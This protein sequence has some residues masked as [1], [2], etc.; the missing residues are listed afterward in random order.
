MI[1]LIDTR[2]VKKSL[3]LL[4][5]K[6]PIY[7]FLLNHNLS[8]EIS[9]IFN[10]P[11]EGDSQV[12][13]DIL[14]GY[15]SFF[16]ETINYKNSI[17][18]KNTSTDLWKEE[19]H[20][21]SWVRDLRAV[22]TNKAR[23]FLRKSI[24]DWILKYNKW[25]LT[26]W[27]SDIIGKRVYSLLGNFNFF[28]S[29]AENDFQKLMLESLF[30]QGNHL[31]KNKLQDIHGY[32]RIFAIKGLIAVSITYTKFNEH[33]DFAIK[34]LITEISNQ[35]LNDGSHYLKSPSKHSEFLQN[36]IDIRSYL[37]EAKYK[38]P[39]KINE[40]ILIMASVLKFY[41]I[42]GETLATFNNSKSINK[43][44]LNQIILR[45]NSKLKI[46]SSLSCSGFQKISQN[47]INFFMDCGPPVKEDTYAGSLSFELSIGKNPI[48]VNCGSPY[49]NNKI[50]T[51]A[52][53][54]TAAHS[55]LSVDNINSSDIFFNKRQ[56][57]SRIANVW[58]QRKKQ[59]NCHWIDAAHSGYKDIFGLIHSR[60]IHIDSE[61]KIIRGQDCLSRSNKCYQKISKK[62]Y[63]RFH[64]FPDI[65]INVTGSKKKAIL[66]LPDGT[67]W[68]FICS[69]PEIAI[70]ESIYLGKKQKISRNNHILVSNSIIP[71]KKI[72]WL[73]RLIK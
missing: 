67:G 37:A 35:V 18:E 53:K 42:N 13:Y 24:Y 32:E 58:S 33:I 23:F 70:R 27:R 68:E 55:T 26:E 51:E 38:T 72:R 30:K 28:C 6:T 50:W 34:L 56:K 41:K 64:L 2:I 54:S 73:F 59:K 29:S 48:I 44:L 43:K 39:K 16:G 20:S 65:E 66:K 21:F 4:Y 57:N 40:C 49:I 69:E 3:H 22:G 71:E 25:S 52:M 8:K 31:I 17:W 1:K 7:D 12:G 46:P 9:N 47:K 63:L 45:A 5:Y 60:K 62:Y 10:D 36:L 61:K 15:V 19:L 11:W 14:Q